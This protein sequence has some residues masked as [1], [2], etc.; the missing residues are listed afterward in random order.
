VGNRVERAKRAG[1][2]VVCLSRA[3][4]KSPPHIQQ[5]AEFPDESGKTQ[6]FDAPPVETACFGPWVTGLPAYST[7]SCLHHWIDYLP[8]RHRLQIDLIPTRITRASHLIAHPTMAIYASP[9]RILAS[10]RTYTDVCA[11]PRIINKLSIVLRG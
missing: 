1:R 8:C 3:P 9:P 4:L 10:R 5:V 11:R 6:S 7:A 2:P